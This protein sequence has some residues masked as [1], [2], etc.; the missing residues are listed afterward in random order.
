MR[1]AFYCTT[2]Q[3][4]EAL[5][6]EL[7]QELLDARR[8]CFVESCTSW[9]HLDVEENNK[10]GNIVLWQHAVHVPRVVAEK[11]SSA[12]GTMRAPKQRKED[13]IFAS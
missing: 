10:K 6:C 2:Q 9:G 5:L 8:S 13:A 7:F 1:R 4:R 12:N 3:I 11:T